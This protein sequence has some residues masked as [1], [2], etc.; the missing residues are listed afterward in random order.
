MH[1]HTLLLS[2]LSGF[3]GVLDE[4]RHDVDAAAAALRPSAHVRRAPRRVHVSP[5]AVPDVDDADLQ[6][7]CRHLVRAWERAE[8]EAIHCVETHES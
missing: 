3:P 6:P 5:G 2:C 8:K 1:V 7:P 4:P